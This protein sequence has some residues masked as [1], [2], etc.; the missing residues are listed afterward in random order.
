MRQV[1]ATPAEDCAH[2]PDGPD[3][4]PDVRPAAVAAWDGLRGLAAEL[5][6]AAGATVGMSAAAAAALLE[7]GG[8]FEGMCAAVGDGG[9]RQSA[10]NLTVYHYLGPEVDVQCSLAHLRTDNTEQYTY[11]DTSATADN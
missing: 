3:E 10:T 11:V 2:W 1:R 4:A 5:L 8:E 9:G 6:Q 7:P